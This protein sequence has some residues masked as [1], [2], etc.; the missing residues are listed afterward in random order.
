MKKLSSSFSFFFTVI[1]PAILFLVGF[2]SLLK[3]PEQGKGIIFIL[4]SILISLLTFHYKAVYITK[5]DL[6]VKGFFTKAVIPLNKIKAIN[7]NRVINTRPIKIYFT[8]K[9]EVGKSVTFMPYSA[10]TFF[11]SHPAYN[12]LKQ[13]V[14]NVN[15]NHT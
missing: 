8:E 3:F 9:T 15:Q 4:A 5:T 2:F 14:Q 11:S 1:I 13:A 12:E 6:V 10:F 7:E